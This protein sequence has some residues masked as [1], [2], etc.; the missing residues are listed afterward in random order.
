MRPRR[1][2]EEKRRK[3]KRSSRRK[4]LTTRGREGGRRRGRGEEVWW[5]CGRWGPRRGGWETE[6]GGLKGTAW[7]RRG[8][9]RWTGGWCSGWIE[10]GLTVSGGWLRVFR[11]PQRGGGERWSS[12]GWG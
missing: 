3:K 4:G 8:G 12:G 1:G 9:D 7:M 11:R 5:E 2:E 6:T 10:G